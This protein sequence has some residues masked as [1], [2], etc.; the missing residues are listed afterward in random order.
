MKRLA[1]ALVVIGLLA[2]SQVTQ[3]ANLEEGW[4][5]KLGGVA[6]Y[7]VDPKTGYDRGVD[8]NF[9]SP[10][11]VS[12]PFDVA[13]PDMLWPQRL[14]SVPYDVTGV[15]FGTGVDLYGQPEPP[16]DFLVQSIFFICD[17]FYE[18]S[19]MRLELLIKRANGNTELIWSQT[20]SGPVLGGPEIPLDD[21]FGS[22]DSFVFRVTT[23]PEPSSLQVLLLTSVPFVLGLMRRF[24]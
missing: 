12:G 14:V 16:V 4:Y 21:L 1:I 13:Q 3:A 17:T 15:I 19:Q 9:T 18:A 11:G 22:D 20:R 10:L 8:W 7:G 24:R 5:V 23:V 6:L 2:V